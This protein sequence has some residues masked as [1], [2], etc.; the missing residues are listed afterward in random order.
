M[1]VLIVIKDAEYPMGFV[2]AYQEPNLTR[3]DEEED[4]T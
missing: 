1:V 4:R 3:P 2:L